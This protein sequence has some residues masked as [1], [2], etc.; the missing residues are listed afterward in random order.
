MATVDRIKRQ[1]Q[2]LMNLVEYAKWKARRDD[3]VR[4]AVE[5]GITKSDVAVIIGV[6]RSTV[7]DILARGQDGVSAGKG[8]V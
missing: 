8:Q 7:Y 1:N 6:T 5:A 4:E 2:A 3:L